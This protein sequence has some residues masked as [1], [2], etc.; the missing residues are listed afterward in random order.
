MNKPN[1][2]ATQVLAVIAVV[3]AVCAV[4]TVWHDGV[5]EL[6]FSFALMAFGAGSSSVILGRDWSSRR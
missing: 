4:L 6:A 1:R 3:S 5:D 2:R